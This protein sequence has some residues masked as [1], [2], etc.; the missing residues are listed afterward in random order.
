LNKQKSELAASDVANRTRIEAQIFRN[1]E[2]IKA[3]ENGFDERFAASKPVDSFEAGSVIGE[4]LNKIVDELDARSKKGFDKIR[5]D[6]KKA[7]IEV[8]LEKKIKMETLFLKL[9]I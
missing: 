8:D 4:N 3:I 2:E 6:L 5:P 1:Q 7:T 9:K